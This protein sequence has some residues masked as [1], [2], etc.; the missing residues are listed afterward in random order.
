MNI[1]IAD[2]VDFEEIA[3]LTPGFVGAD[4]QAVLRESAIHSISRL[5]KSYSIANT[6]T[7][8]LIT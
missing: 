8:I 6:V 2:D 3:N 4:L 1:K 5:F 7:L